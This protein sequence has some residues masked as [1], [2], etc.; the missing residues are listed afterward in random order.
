LKFFP[1]VKGMNDYIMHW[2]ERDE[3]SEQRGDFQTGA[4][5][6]QPGSDLLQDHASLT[7]MQSA[8]LGEPPTD[9]DV[10]CV[11]DSRIVNGYDF[12]FAANI[13]G[14]YPG[15]GWSANFKVPTGY[16]A[17]PR[18]W[19][20]QFDL[21]PTGIAANS[22]ATIQQNGAALP[23][24]TVI[25][26]MGTDEPI[27]TFFLCEENTSFGIA[28]INSNASVTF[29]GN[30]NVYGNLIPVTSVALPLAVSNQRQIGSGQV[31]VNS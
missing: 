4:S 1:E 9:F 6:D 15:Y 19:S 23:N 30:V 11:F 18:K 8:P 29:T 24:N 28:G 3:F 7:A 17:I 21:P 25:I 27:E 22:T 14:S 2:W 5:W 26:G 10:R 16:R 12:N 13:S 20:V 31:G